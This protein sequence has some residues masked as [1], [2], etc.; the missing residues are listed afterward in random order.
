MNKT[1]FIIYAISAIL[2]IHAV[3]YANY[4]DRKVDKITGDYSSY[5]LFTNVKRFAL[6]LFTISFVVLAI[7]PMS[8]ADGMIPPLFFIILSSIW[9]CTAFV[10][11]AGP[12]RHGRRIVRR[13]LEL[14]SQGKL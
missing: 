14:K 5:D 6:T 9:G 4:L 11:Y 2:L 1:I 13:L 7:I 8:V 3:A 10:I 12:V